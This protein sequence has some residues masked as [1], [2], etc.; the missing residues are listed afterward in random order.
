MLRL[1][2]RIPN[3][4]TII[5]ILISLIPLTFFPFLFPSLSVSELGSSAICL[6]TRGLIGL[7][8]TRTTRCCNTNILMESISPVCMLD[9]DPLPLSSAGQETPGERECEAIDAE[10]CEVHFTP[11][12]CCEGISQ[13]LVE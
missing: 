3:L 2:E 8:M 9:P 5:F 4:I 10:Q 11:L 7:D 6:P 13:T 1:N 12:L